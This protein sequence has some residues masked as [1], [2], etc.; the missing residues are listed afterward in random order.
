MSL[1]QLQLHRHVLEQQIEELRY[2]N[3]ELEAS[4]NKYALLY[5]FAPVG[6]FTFDRSARIRTVNLT[7]VTML[8]VDRA[9]LANLCFDHFVAEADRFIF[10]DFLR[11]VFQGRDKLTCR[12]KLSIPGKPALY[13]RIEAMTTGEGD[14]CNAA[15]LDITERKRAEEFLRE[16]EY[17][18]AKAQSM[19]HVGSWR[20]DPLTGELRVSDELLRIMG[21]SRE[22]ATP[23]ALADLIHPDDRESVLALMRQGSEQG[24]NYE[25]EHRLLLKDGTSKWVYTIV[26]P[27]VNIARQVVTLYGTTQDI[28]ER[29]QNEVRLRNKSNELQAI[30]DAVNDGVIVFDHN[31]RIQHLNHIIP[32]FFPEEVLSG[33]GCRDVFHPEGVHHPTSLGLDL[34]G[35]TRRCHT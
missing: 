11:R 18:L 9:L 1:T 31:G 7:G 35:T 4:R 26:E 8:G 24:S 29:K 33:G 27:A 30:F 14:E 15:L 20:S 23:E 34:S 16:S 2:A 10:A 22:E 3:Q 21:L 13:V 19:S 6:Y 25:I 32:Q 5:D 28:T 12:V 17:N